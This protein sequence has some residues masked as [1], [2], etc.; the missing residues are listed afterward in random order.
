MPFDS[1]PQSVL[2]DLLALA[3]K[4]GAA[5]ADVSLSSSESLT[6]E[7]RLGALEGVERS[8][9][10][11]IALRALLG[12]RQAAAT[13]TDM[14]PRGLA[15]LADRVVAMARMAPEDPFCGLADPATLARDI[16]DLDMEDTAA[17]SAHELEEV[18]R[19]AEDAGR[20]IPGVT[21]SEGAGADFN[22]G[23]SAYAT[24][25]GFYAYRRGTSYGV[26]M[27][28][29]AERDGQKEQG[30]EGRNE[31]FRASLPDPVAIGREAGARA[32]AQLGARKIASCR[33]P[34]IF[35]A[36]LAGALIGPFL[37]A[38]SGAAVARG[39]SF[40]KDQLGKGV[41]AAGFEIADDPLRPRGMSSRA[42]DG[43]GVAT[44]PR[45][46][47]DDGALTTWMLNTPA[48]RQLGMASTGHATRGHGGPPGVGASNIVVKP[49]VGSFA[50]LLRQ[51]GTGLVV[52]STF[53]P[54]IN[55]NT[56]DY[57]VGVAGWWFENGERAFP[58]SEVTIAGNLRDIYKRVIPGGDLERRGG[59]D[60]PSLL[61]DDLTIAGI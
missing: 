7:V 55:A 42:F 13:S 38:I 22:H 6:V 3:R 23:A 17:P 27:S 45:K 56:G 8:E 32:V 2:T 36:R 24:S 49:G 15:E 29:L 50:D 57:S 61:I 1:D 12:K 40:L 19:A 30:Y 16:Q 20:A 48:A 10:R 25:A 37:G 18:A 39:I 59:L 33:A 41:F 26:G 4:A 31:R 44:S 46:L 14:S 52:T 51:A 54:S 11:S 21:N 43:E 34:V 47:I 5:D 9:G 58:V 28:A 35:E 60:I 53:S